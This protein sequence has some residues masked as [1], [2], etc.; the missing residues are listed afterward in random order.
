MGYKRLV[1]L[2]AL[3]AVLGCGEDKDKYGLGI[4]DFDT[5]AIVSDATP[6]QLQ[7]ASLNL[8]AAGVISQVRD[9]VYLSQASNTIPNMIESFQARIDELNA[10]TSD[11]EEDAVPDCLT[12][13]AT[14]ASVTTPDGQSMSMKVQCYEK[15]SD[16]SFMIWGQDSDGVSFIFERS[17]ASVSVVK[18]TPQA[19]GTNIFDGYLSSLGESSDA[20]TVVHMI[21][22]QSTKTLQANMTAPH[23]L[24]AVNLYADETK[25][26]LRGSVSTGTA[27][28]C[29][30]E[31]D[32]VFSS[33]DLA[34]STGFDAS[35]L[36][37]DAY[38]MKRTAGTKLVNGASTAYEEYANTSGAGNVSLATAADPSTS[39]TDVNFGP[40][41]ADGLGGTLFAPK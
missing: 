23:E 5:S 33:T 39:T 12:A 37:A 27:N 36:M 8:D 35:L 18:V 21:A 40:A 19:D 30:A 28:A 29:P 17:S 4:F 6:S 26:H 16:T 7:A 2:S 14:D 31:A 38:F 24:C 32:Y 3:M 22:N 25:I 11:L 9:R 1:L 34:E 41:A 15:L 20:G 13:T 10:R